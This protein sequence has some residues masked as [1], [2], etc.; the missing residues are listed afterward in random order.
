ME[1]TITNRLNIGN[2]EIYIARIEND[3]TDYKTPLLIK[4]EIIDGSMYHFPYDLQS[5]ETED[6]SQILEVTKR[7]GGSL[8]LRLNRL[9]EQDSMIIANAN[10]NDDLFFPVQDTVIQ[11]E[12]QKNMMEVM[13][14]Q[15]HVEASKQKVIQERL[16]QLI[17]L[18]MEIESV[19]WHFLM[20]TSARPIQQL[21]YI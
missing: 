3:V 19:K 1:V 17:K 18:L 15:A 4:K 21:E 14:Q 13:T 16:Q 5:M 10:E 6:F 2:E 12:K 8:A 20:M 11:F 9:G 7:E